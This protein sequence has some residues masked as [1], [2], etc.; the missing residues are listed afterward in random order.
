MTYATFA[1]AARA[2]GVRLDDYQRSRIAECDRDARSAGI[3]LML[4][5]GRRLS[6]ARTAGGVT[7]EVIK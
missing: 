5:K 3:D 1:L 4:S 7:F 6:L 2:A